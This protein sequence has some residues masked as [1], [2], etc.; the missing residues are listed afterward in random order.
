MAGTRRPWLASQMIFARST[1]RAAAVRDWASCRTVSDS[2]GV[3]GR[4]WSAMGNLPSVLRQQYQ[5][6]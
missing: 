4:T 2:S 6:T 5:H 3:R 1:V